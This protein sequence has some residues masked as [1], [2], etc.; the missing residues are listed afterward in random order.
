MF[1]Q[2]ALNEYRQMS[3]T[4]KEN[5]FCTKICIEKKLNVATAAWALSVTSCG[6]VCC[7]DLNVATVGTDLLSWGSRHINSTALY[8]LAIL[9]ALRSNSGI[10][11]VAVVGDVSIVD[12]HID[13]LTPVLVT[14]KSLAVNYRLLFLLQRQWCLALHTMCIHWCCLMVT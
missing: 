8:D 12:D 5:I 2:P 11:R 4:D 10:A 7:R 13:C 14:S 1:V 6:L 9:F 3:F